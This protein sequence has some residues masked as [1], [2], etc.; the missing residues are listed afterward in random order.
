VFSMEEEEDKERETVKR[1]S[2]GWNYPVGGRSPALAATAR[3][4]TTSG[5]RIEGMFGVTR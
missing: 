2:G 4:G 1:N 5:G 3:N